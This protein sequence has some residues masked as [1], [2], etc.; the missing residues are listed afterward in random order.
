M[1]QQLKRIPYVREAWRSVKKVRKAFL[2][3]FGAEIFRRKLAAAPSKRIVIG[4]GFKPQPGWLPTQ[5][6]FLNLLK[7]DD[8]ERFFAPATIDAM[9]AEHVWEH[10]TLEEGRAAAGLCFKYLKPGGYL[11]VAVPDGN[12]PSPA[13]HEWV[14]VGGRSP[15]QVANDHKV[16]YTHGT[17]RSLFERAGF[18]VNLFE[19]FDED[20]G[21]HFHEWDERAGKIWRSKRFDS[22]N[23][24]GELVFTSVVLDA[25]KD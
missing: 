12:H 4:A 13:Y 15:M 7:P 10:L 2:R 17:L 16:L 11:R 22:R 6:E 18:R 9:L 23:A 25:V 19:Y 8:W 3:R 14:R 5:I 1:R 21:F 20:G 24:G